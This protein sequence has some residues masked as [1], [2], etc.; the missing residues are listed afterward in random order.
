MCYQLEYIGESPILETEDK[1]LR[2]NTHSLLRLVELVTLV[3]H[4]YK[5]R[6]QQARP[7]HNG[8]TEASETK[9]RLD[10]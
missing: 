3:I 9:P 4:S 7:S 8:C 2:L 6:C 10:S 1:L 5:E